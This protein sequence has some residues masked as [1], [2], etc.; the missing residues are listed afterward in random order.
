MSGDVEATR[1]VLL[2]LVCV[3]SVVIWLKNKGKIWEVLAFSS[4]GALLGLTFGLVG[5]GMALLC[6]FVWSIFKG[7]FSR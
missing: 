1:N 6:I 2:L 4:G 7:C 3:V 5:V